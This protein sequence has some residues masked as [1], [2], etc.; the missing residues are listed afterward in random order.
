MQPEDQ[1]DPALTGP[2]D[3]ELG[4]CAQGHPVNRYGR[5]EPLNTGDETNDEEQS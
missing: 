5:C 1:Q 3:A 4:R 2:Y